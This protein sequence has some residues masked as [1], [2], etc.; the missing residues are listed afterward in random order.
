VRISDAARSVDWIKTEYAN[1]NSPDTFATLGEE[2]NSGQGDVSPV[3]TEV[4]EVPASGI[5]TTPAYTFS[6]TKS[7]TITYSG[8]CSSATTSA[9]VGDNTV[10]FNTLAVGAHS[11]CSLQV[12]DSSGHAS[13]L[14]VNPFVITLRPSITS[15]TSTLT[16]GSYGV[17]NI[18]PITVNFSKAVTSTGNVLVTLNTTPSASCSFSVTNATSGTCNY[19][20][21]AGDRTTNGLDITQIAGSI[22][23]QQGN[24]LLNFTP[25]A[26]LSNS[27][28]IRID[29]I[30]APT[31]TNLIRY[32]FWKPG[33]DPASYEPNW[34]TLTHVVS[35]YW[36]TN[37]DGT[38]SVKYP[39][40]E[41][42][43]VKAAARQHGLKVIMGVTSVDAD[44]MDNV[45]ANH[46][47]EFACCHASG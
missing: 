25:A 9:A 37:A 23:D 30:S 32:G 17:G 27:K 1:Q 13:I 16:N 29:T 45:L 38:L 6:S 44:A 4:V 5:A 18:I 42:N 40:S 3:L 10:T 24:A 35:G 20:T 14:S 2:E 19:V 33:I 31:T 34:D 41:Y 39:I 22:A 28:T 7:G 21:R 26:S 11:N 46:R 43:A 15:I 12:T 8:D 47:E 36:T